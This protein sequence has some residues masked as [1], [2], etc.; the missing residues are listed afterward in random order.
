MA[1]TRKIVVREQREIHKGTRNGRDFIIYQVVA[2]T[3]GGVPIEQNLRSFQQ[4]PK[5]QLIDVDIEKYESPQSGAVSYTVS[6]KKQG[7]SVGKKVSELEARMDTM[8]REF[9]KLVK[10]VEQLE[11]RG[12]QNGAAPPSPVA[13]T[14][15]PAAPQ[16]T[17][18]PPPLAAEGSGGQMPTD[19]IPF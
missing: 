3:E 6:T 4:L 17:Q 10:R 2:T 7:S 16:P 15:P 1:G 19:D 9:A 8:A 18:Q 5:N 14:P 13:A 12:G 11:G